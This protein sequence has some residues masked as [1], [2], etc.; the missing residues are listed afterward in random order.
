MLLD[1]SLPSLPPNADRRALSLDEESPPSEVYTDTP[2][3]VPTSQRTRP[4]GSRSRSENVPAPSN[5]IPRA[6]QKRPPHP[7]SQSSKSEKREAS[8]PPEEDRKEN[9]VIPNNTNRHSAYS[10]N[11][12]NSGPGNEFI[13]MVL[14]SNPAPGPSPLVRRDNFQREAIS[15]PQSEHKMTSRDYFNAKNNIQ[16]KPTREQE[17]SPQV[18]HFQD[19][20]NTSRHSS[21]PNSPH[22]AYQERGR[23][24]S[25]EMSEA[26]R[27]KKEHQGSNSI[28]AIANESHREL[29]ND[30][31]SKRNGDSQQN[32]KFML[33]EVPK[34]K[35]AERKVSKDDAQAPSLDTNFS[36]SASKSAPN[37]AGA[38]VREQQVAMPLHG[39]PASSSSR[40]DAT[41][42]GSPQ[43]MPGVRKT[44]TESPPVHSSPLATQLTTLPERGD[45]LAKGMPGKMTVTMPLPRREVETAAVSKFPGP[46]VPESTFEKPASAPPTTTT[47]PPPP[48]PPPPTAS[49]A[50]PAFGRGPSR[51]QE[52]PAST[53]FNDVPPPPMRA[54]ERL[55]LQTATAG[56]TFQ[57]PRAPPQ[58][59]APVH[60]ARNGSVSAVRPEALR[61]GDQPSTPKTLRN[62]E[63]SESSAA[64]EEAIR[65]LGQDPLAEGSGFLRRVSN[66]V[67][68]ARSYSD[69]GTRISR[70]QKWPKSP[71][72]GSQSPSV[73]HDVG[74]PLSSSPET[75]EEILWFKNELR[76]ERQKGM[77]K[78]QRLT[79]LEA[80]LEGK[81]SIKQMNSELREKRSTMVVLDTQKEIVIRELEVLTEHIASATKNS[82]PLDIGKLS[83]TVLREFAES[84]QKLKESFAPQ[85]E[86][87]TQQRNDL[88]DEVS[89]LTQLKDKSFQEFERLSE[90]NAQ[91]ADLNNQLVHQIQELYKANAGP[92]LDAARPPPN[93]LG[94]YTQKDRPGPLSMESRN[95]RPSLTESNLTG[96]T[97]VPDQ[98]VDGGAYLASPQVVNIRKAQPKKFNWKKQGHNVA[99]GVKGLKGAFSSDPNRGQ[100]EGQLTEGTPYGAMSQQEYPSTLHARAPGLDRREGFGAFFGDRKQ[101]PQQ[102]KNSPNGSSPAVHADNGPRKLLCTSHSL[103][104]IC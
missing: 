21:Q 67:R 78:D 19:S 91:L 53:N 93:G 2:T 7:R 60:Q 32:G 37:S 50:I 72:L 103:V 79:E 18:H 90:K 94:I 84:L 26:G 63:K 3:E 42:S 13:P 48:P 11:S 85:I 20:P 58:P 76:R 102:W 28:N 86:D 99:K 33:Q 49:G 23:Q 27:R 24:L 39:S 97:A 57:T 95:E 16:R 14:D 9:L 10:Q 96:S 65:A 73:G 35:K 71:M 29:I 70:E 66:S 8:P 17:D 15:P 74:S 41:L 62:V 89:N 81:S 56:D 61:N 25:S 82:E 98:E 59:P 6:A 69:R 31:R 92:G 12:D 75:R 88:L 38:Q 101:R 77:E 5:D 43:D 36:A 64:D 55:A 52:S 44:S 87:L 51:P 83:N 22:I 80:A 47:Q 100:R 104:S 54:K 4:S 30:L 34:N 40:S 45:S 46:I 68:H 1:K